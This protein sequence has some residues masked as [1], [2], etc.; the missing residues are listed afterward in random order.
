[1]MPAAM[2]RTAWTSATWTWRSRSARRLTSGRAARIRSASAKC[3][4]A[5]ALGGWVVI[6]SVSCLWQGFGQVLGVVVAHSPRARNVARDTRRDTADDV[7]GDAGRI[8][9]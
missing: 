6:G 8:H 4:P 2:L 5:A 1:M 9:G 3:S 7:S